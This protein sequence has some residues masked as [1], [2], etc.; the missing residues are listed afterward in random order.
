MDD[1]DGPDD[2]VSPSFTD[3]DDET[4]PPPPLHGKHGEPPSDEEEHEPTLYDVLYV[5]ADASLTDLRQAY[6]QQALHWHPDKNSDPEAEERFKAVNQA[7]RVLSDEQQRASYDRSLACGSQWVEGGGGSNFQSC[8]DDIAA[9]R[10]YWAAFQAAEEEARRVEVRRERGL[11]VGICSLA[12]W[13][14]LILLLLWSTASHMPCLFPPALELSNL[15][16]SRLP[17][18]LDFDS[19]RERLDARHRAQLAQQHLPDFPAAWRRTLP[20]ALAGVVLRT[21]TP[22][23][24]VRLNRTA[25]IRRAPEVGRAG[26][27]GYLLVSSHHAEDIYGRPIDM[28]SNTFLYMPDGK[29]AP[30]PDLTVCARLLRSGPIL[31][32]EWWSDMSR[33]LGGRMRTFA[34]AAV[35]NS[36]CEPEFGIA[37]LLSSTTIALAATTMTVRMLT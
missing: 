8:H 36:E 10:A 11:L 24:R 25:E 20:S 27:R 29:P 30:W 12:I 26:G 33:S 18:S 7:W 9:M 15:E 34:L 4:E 22:Y 28:V 23:L 14:A 21:H 3:A 35:P 19:F 37:A 5:T 6:K 32:K 1:I 16:F 13:A 17:L 2:F 31:K